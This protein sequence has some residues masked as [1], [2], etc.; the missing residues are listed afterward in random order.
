MRETLFLGSCETGDTDT[1][2]AKQRLSTEDKK[3][4]RNTPPTHFSKVHP[5]TIFQS[6]F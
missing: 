2:A 5:A 3:E 4:V 1:A 6:A